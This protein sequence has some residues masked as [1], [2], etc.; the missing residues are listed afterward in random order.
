MSASHPTSG[1]DRSTS[2][3]TVGCTS[4]KLSVPSFPRCIL[5]LI[6]VACVHGDESGQ[7]SK[8]AG[9]YDVDNVKREYSSE[10]SSDVSKA[11]RIE[12][13]NGDANAAATH[14]RRR[15]FKKGKVVSR[16][17]APGLPPPPPP[18][19][20]CS[21]CSSGEYL[22]Q[23]NDLMHA[24]VSRTLILE[25]DSHHILFKHACTLTCKWSLNARANA[26]HAH[27][28]HASASMNLQA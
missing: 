8:R 5:L 26:S 13:A 2:C 4:R 11:R 22:T 28:Q 19:S 21:P 15:R 1:C 18:T 20:D 25:V 17:C 14:F 27:I 10:G 24:Y 3:H 16:Q 23:G 12:A 7:R 6:F 9:K